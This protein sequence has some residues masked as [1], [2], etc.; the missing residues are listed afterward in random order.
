M[1]PEELSSLEIW[2][3]GSVV[4]SDAGIGYELRFRGKEVSWGYDRLPGVSS[5]THAELHALILAL[6]EAL[7]YE[8]ATCVYVY[9]DSQSA[10]EMIDRSEKATAHSE[11]LQVLVEQARQLIDEFEF[12]SISCKPKDQNERADDLAKR[13]HH[14][15]GP[16]EDPCRVEIISP[17]GNQKR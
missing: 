4:D 10:V 12:S 6:E 5:S 15:L 7:R 1:T 2:A 13:A 3:D 9:S 16:D 11:S 14:R 17:Q 8:Q